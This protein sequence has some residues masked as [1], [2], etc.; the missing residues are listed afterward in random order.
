[1]F[2]FLCWLEKEPRVTG[3]AVDIYIWSGESLQSTAAKIAIKEK[4]KTN[5]DLY[6]SMLCY[7]DKTPQFKILVL[8]VST[9]SAER[10]HQTQTSKTAQPILKTLA[11][12]I[13]SSSGDTLKLNRG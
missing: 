9:P 12:K 10:I 7:L 5:E 13:R 6:Y 3:S 11:S 4:Q 1:M 8:I 2:I